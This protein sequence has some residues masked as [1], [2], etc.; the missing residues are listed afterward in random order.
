MVD[1]SGN[2]RSEGQVVYS[3][4]SVRLT[5]SDI[6]SHKSLAARNNFAFNTQEMKKK[7]VHHS[8]L[9][10]FRPSYEEILP[11]ALTVIEVFIFCKFL[12]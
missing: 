1:R 6:L 7:K 8:E 11:T 12:M 3:L 9:T 4:M 2:I 10:S 5:T